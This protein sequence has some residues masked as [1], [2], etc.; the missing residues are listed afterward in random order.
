MANETEPIAE[1][2][3]TLSEYQSVR[4]P[5][6]GGT[7]KVERGKDGFR[8]YTPGAVDSV[9]RAADAWSAAAAVVALGGMQQPSSNA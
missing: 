7:I 1:R 5:C 4:F 6:D 9:E 3:R 8:I 2:L